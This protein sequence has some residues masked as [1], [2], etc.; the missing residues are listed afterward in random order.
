MA[1]WRVVITD[2]TDSEYEIEA[3]VFARSGLDIDLVT[4][5][6]SRERGLRAATADAD[7]LLVQFAT[8][9]RA[10]IESLTSCRV[11]SRYGI[12][13]DMI[14]LDA[15]S[16]C[17][18][19]VANV[20]DFCIDEVSTQTIGFVIDLN[21][22]T[23]ELSAH[24]RSGLWGSRP[25]VAAPRRLSGQT[26][27]IVGFGAIGRQVS[28]KAE[29]LGLTVLAYDPY[30]K[31]EAAANVALVS[32]T[33]LLERSDYVSL[34]C[35]LNESTR[36]LIGEAEL[37]RM[38]RT[39]YLLNLSRGPVV[40]QDALVHALASGG[41][42]GAAL[43]VLVTEPPAPGDPILQLDNVIVTPHTASWSVESAQKLRH[44]AAQNVVAALTGDVPRS[45]VNRDQLR[46]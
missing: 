30:L 20:P 8:I 39:A 3:R 29:A 22:H 2:F 27:G 40:D 46:R 38:K 10:L 16:A 43:D 42:E 23:L 26:L 5:A 19:P 15:A 13:V 37:A 45:V 1:P 33:E 41:I 14:D 6:E 21:R 31:P 18:I 24:V 25:P 7:A 44:D 9:D 17:G 34:H 32:L 35:P 11:I 36:G 12:G 28:S 4:A